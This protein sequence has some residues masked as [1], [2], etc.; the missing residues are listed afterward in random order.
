MTSLW[1]IPNI[2]NLRTPLSILKE[3]AAALTDDTRGLL[4]GDVKTDEDLDGYLDLTLI[5]R[6][7][8]LN[9]YSYSVLTYT[10][11]I[12]LFPGTMRSNAFATSRTVKSEEEFMFNLKEALQSPAITMAVKGL[13]A[14]A[15]SS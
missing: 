14:Q 4:V 6:V 15:A 13:L 10:Q 3:Q 5:I 11:P 9:N 1:S 12:T 8:S 2:D 7:P